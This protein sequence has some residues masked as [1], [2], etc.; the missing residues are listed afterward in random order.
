MS[1]DAWF[2]IIIFGDESPG[3]TMF[4]QKYLT[5]LFVSDKTMTIGVDFEVKSVSVDGQKVMLQ[6]WDFGGEERFRFLLH[7]YVRGARGGMFLY[8]IADSSSIARIDYW[9][10]IIRKELRAEE[11]F[12]ILVVG[13]LPDERNDRQVAREE[14]VEIANSKNLDGYI[15]CNPKTG[16][17]VERAFEAL[18]R[19]MLAGIK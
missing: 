6:I 12:S 8:D 19:L 13:L 1:Y 15:E 4:I 7:T 11:I 2:K 14:R 5:N 10:S 17:N 16:E 18:T 3:K 9:L